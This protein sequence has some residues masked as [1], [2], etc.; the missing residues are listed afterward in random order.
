MK[1]ID[2]APEQGPLYTL[3][4]F[5]SAYDGGALLGGGL[6]HTRRFE[7]SGLGLE[8]E[9]FSLFQNVRTGSVAYP[10]YFSVGT[11]RKRGEGLSLG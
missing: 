2:T 1:V 8:Q 4:L 10:A 6:S 9:H 7:I 5:S 11:S 3:A